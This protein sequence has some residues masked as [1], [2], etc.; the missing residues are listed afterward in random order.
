MTFITTVTF[1]LVIGFVFG[2]LYQYLRD[3][4]RVSRAVMLGE[5]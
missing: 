1:S 3:D 4:E 2:R 5:E